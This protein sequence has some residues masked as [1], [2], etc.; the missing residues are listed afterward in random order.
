MCLATRRHWVQC[1]ACR[2]NRK[3]CVN[4]EILIGRR[5][6][7]LGNDYQSTTATANTVVKAGQQT[8]PYKRATLTALPQPLGDNC[9]PS[10]RHFV[11]SVQSLAHIYVNKAVLIEDSL[12]LFV[13][14]FQSNV[15]C[16]FQYQE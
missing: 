11:K 9:V 14:T 3:A 15:F 8:I 12:C 7:K 5:L 10:E 16:V 6:L 2:P 4:I 1:S 13:W